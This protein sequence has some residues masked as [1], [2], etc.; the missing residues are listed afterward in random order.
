MDTR[1]A[2]IIAD[3]QAAV[4]RAV[5]LFA[6]S[7][8]PRPSSTMEWVSNGIPQIGELKGGI[9]YFK[10]GYGCQVDLPTGSV[11]F[12][13]GAEGQIHGFDLWRL[14]RFTDDRLAHYG[15]KSEKDLQEAFES[16]V[17]SGELVYSGYILHYVAEHAA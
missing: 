13:F 9:P 10:H 11:D 4:R 16:A 5:D 2:K 12:D 7:N 17:R 8:I 14:S 15:F 6:E 3:Y 1:L